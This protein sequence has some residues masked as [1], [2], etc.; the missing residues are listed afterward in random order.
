MSNYAPLIVDTATSAIKELP[1]GG[2]LDLSDS[3][4][5]NA[6]TAV[7]SLPTVTSTLATLAG[8]ET[9]TNKTI[10]TPTVAN[11]TITGTTVFG[12]NSNII[13][14]P[15]STIYGNV[16]LT[17]PYQPTTDNPTTAVLTVGGGIF[18]AGNLAVNS[19]AAIVGG[20]ALGSAIFDTTLS[21]VPLK[22]EA[23]PA[24]LY[25]QAALISKT[26]T[27]SADWAAYG[28]NYASDGTSGWVDMGFTGNAFSDPAYT[29]TK[30]NDGYVFSSARDGAGLGGNLVFA[31]D[32]TGT[33]NDIV[34]GVGSFLTS[35]EVA[36]FHGNA[37]TNGYLQITTG[38]SATST[39]TGALRITGGLGVTG[40]AYASTFVGNIAGDTNGTS[41]VYVTGSL[42][43]A[44]NVTYDLGSQ[45][46][47]FRDLWLSGT[48][49]YI[50]TSTI[51][52]TGGDLI[53][54]NP[55]GA[56]FT[57]S[58]SGASATGSFGNVVATSG[59]ASTNSSTGALRVTGGA[60]ISGALNIGGSASIGE[61]LTVA[62][63]LT[64]N[65]NVVTINTQTLDVE[66]LN[67]TIAKGAI[68]A[69]AANGAG[70]TVDGANATFTY[71]SAGDNWALNKPITVTGGITTTATI[72]ASIVNAAIIGNSGATLTGTL[73]TA[74]QPNITSV[75]TLTSLNVGAITS[76]GT[77]IASTVNASTIG[78]SGATLTGTL[79]TAS[80][81]NITS[82]GSLSAV[83][84]NNTPIG[85]ATPSTG[86]FTTLSASGTTTLTG[87]VTANG[88]VTLG[89]STD[90]ITNISG[91]TSI[92]T[93]SVTT[94]TTSSDQVLATASATTFRSGELLIQGVDATDTKYHTAKILFAHN[95][96]TVTY[97]EYGSV[98]VGGKT[99][100][101]NMDINAGLIRL[102]GTPTSTNSTVFKITGFF[103]LA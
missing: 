56:S 60:G 82:V 63:N 1:Y 29:I 20:L 53:L 7:I 33:Y 31:T 94:T 52:S 71:A 21:D 101:Y 58:G 30:S 84:I 4:I 72:I 88:N 92:V 43:P 67:I 81:P 73:S 59:T 79:S 22:I 65:G 85:N 78:N 80:Q 14:Q 46:K 19:K 16:T 76:S 102:L 70:L 38:T 35:A 26:S 3:K 61:D 50:G 103:T 17:A 90:D 45:S 32:R 55:A 54:T 51:Q 77:I 64:V 75:G 12:A 98:D 69:A 96:T 5:I 68:N 42:I 24:G 93:A 8:T 97:T 91:I 36:R 89:N 11:S 34:F 10:E 9:F 47:R 48:T 6:N 37:S 39:A 49:I 40:S 74:S 95:G 87:D 28:N 18:S 99:A 13:I 57:V 66:D 83:A 15:G 2:N 41:N 23:T 100:T 27:S 62:G 86:A 25:T 44:A